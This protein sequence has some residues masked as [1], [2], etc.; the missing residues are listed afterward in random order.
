MLNGLT[1]VRFVAA[2][3]VFLFHFDLR[4]PI[5][6]PTPI[7]RVI[8]NGALAMPVFFMLSG[9]VL[10]HR[11]QDSYSGFAS[12]LRARVARI[13][14]AYFVSV[15]VAL[16]FATVQQGA[17]AATVLFTIPVD[18][19][20]L[21]AWYPNLYGYWHHAGTWSI[22]VE[23]F[24]YAAF[25]LLLPL[26]RLSTRALI[27]LCVGCTLLAASFIPSLRLGVSTA[28]PF[29]VFYSVPLFSLP[30]FVFG[31]CLAELRRRGQRGSMA[32]PLAL[33]LV[34]GFWGDYNTR[35]AGLNFVTLPLIAVSLLFAAR[36]GTEPG[37]LARLL[38]NRATIYL[39]N[40]SY[41][42]F[43]FQMPLLMLLEYNL[44]VIR[45]QP[46]LA[47]FATMLALNIALAA[48]SR[49]WIEPRGR[50]LIIRHW[51]V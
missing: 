19:L 28:L 34:L 10:A 6:V 15:V 2:F 4:I 20:L 40:I 25:P 36:L 27:Y 29:P 24:L 41:A 3:W 14:P 5:E 43:L 39:G 44:G 12:F 21:Q 11:Y 30:A 17:D 38:V 18:L 46:P 32:A 51:K 13:Y 47:V 23:F 49:R 26:A 35:Y 50:K 1:V 48:I 7:E 42:F 45:E 22:S 9:F 31:V 37:W 8:S 16:P 33:G